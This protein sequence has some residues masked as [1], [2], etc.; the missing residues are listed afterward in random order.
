MAAAPRLAR[1]IL[2]AKQIDVLAAFYGDVLQLP[3]VESPDDSPEF[4]SFDA[5]GCH[6]CLHAIPAH[7]AREIRI[8][9]PPAPR[10]AT[11]YKLAFHASD[12]DAARTELIARGARMGDVQ[13]FGALAFCDGVDPEGNIFQFSNR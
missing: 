1:V 6:L 2:F 9:D 10:A 4:L 7:F 5:G 13:R 12:V 11:P 8:A 3:R